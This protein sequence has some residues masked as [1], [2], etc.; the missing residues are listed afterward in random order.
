MSTT[1]SLSSPLAPDNP[2][3]ILLSYKPSQ[4]WRH[5]TLLPLFTAH[6]PPRGGGATSGLGT[7]TTAGSGGGA[8]VVAANGTGNTIGISI[9]ESTTD[10][11]TTILTSYLS[12]TSNPSAAA[13][14]LIA[15]AADID[16][17][18]RHLVQENAPLLA[19]TA[20]QLTTVTAKLT[21][22]QAK[23]HRLRTSYAQAHRP[24]TAVVEP[25]TQAVNAVQAITRTTALLKPVNRALQLVDKLHILLPPSAVDGK[26]AALEDRKSAGNQTDASPTAAS[27]FTDP[28]R[29][30][31]RAATHI[32]ELT[33]LLNATPQLT[34]ITMLSTHLP[35][36]QSALSAITTHTNNALAA[37]IAEDAQSNIGNAFQVYYNLGS[38]ALAAA[39]DSAVEKQR[40]TVLGALKRMTDPSKL[41]ATET[42]NAA[43]A[44]RAGATTGA[45]SSGQQTQSLRNTLFERSNAV[46]ESLYTGAV[47]V[48]VVERVLA[49]KKDPLSQQLFAAEYLS[50][51]TPTIS[52][53]VEEEFKRN[54]ETIPEEPF[55]RGT[56]TYLL[57]NFWTSLCTSI[58]Q[59]VNNASKQSATL[60]S[61][62]SN[63]YPRLIS[64]FVSTFD[65]LSST[66]VDTQHRPILTTEHRTILINAFRVFSQEYN[67]RI[68][69]HLTKPLHAMF[70]D[71]NGSPSMVPTKAD[72]NT[73]LMLVDEQLYGLKGVDVHIQRDILQSVSKSINIL[74][75][76]LEN[77]CILTPDLN[78]FDQ[79]SAPQSTHVNVHASNNAN[80]FNLS[81]IQKNNADLSSFI[82]IILRALETVPANSPDSSRNVLQALDN[83][84]HRLQDLR[85]SLYQ[86][87]MQ[88]VRRGIT[89]VLANMHEVD[90]DLAGSDTSGYMVS[91]Q[92]ALNA[93]TNV[94]LPAY[95][96]GTSKGRPSSK[97]PSSVVDQTHYFLSLSEFIVAAFQRCAALVSPMTDNA[98]IRLAADVSTLDTALSQHLHT[99]ASIRSSLHAFRDLL[100]ADNVSA[101]REVCSARSIDG[102]GVINL[103]LNTSYISSQSCAPHVLLH[104][105]AQE[106]ISKMEDA[107]AAEKAA[108]YDHVLERLFGCLTLPPDQSA[109]IYLTQSHPRLAFA[110]ELIR[111]RQFDKVKC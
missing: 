81:T 58:N 104:I 105:S 74:Y 17:E 92:R 39:V 18:I 77:L 43:A 25:A 102:S 16:T 65:R 103:M 88:S 26:V 90:V 38:D 8:A 107:T 68:V 6:P 98:K 7:Q 73:F 95:V 64:F 76:Q 5:T 28:L 4:P 32:K 106:F 48:W 67:S 20:D 87:L 66:C 99:T 35:Y 53:K 19:S 52:Q 1:S 85:S 23:L 63:E 83:T 96:S 30:A 14:P 71:S 49:K 110:L 94:L 21:A 97:V 56:A 109:E 31:A 47:H 100:F 78:V 75:G 40:S 2:L 24:I 108:G 57:T 12:S 89:H 54:E 72:A 51:K 13:T 79:I 41:S 37:A 86:A 3:A 9:D 80:T 45:S 36:V 60:R 33:M 111:K 70:A 50:A 11:T 62:F 59:E 22:L 91:L 82:T 84:I 15:L 101:I 42:V 69:E 27:G 29:D 61:V 10:L 55:Q 34:E 44:R 93:F 46:A